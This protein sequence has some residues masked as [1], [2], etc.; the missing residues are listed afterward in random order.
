[1]RSATRVGRRDYR[2][3]GGATQSLFPCRNAGGLSGHAELG[4]TGTHFDR[5]EDHNGSEWRP[6]T[7]LPA[8]RSRNPGMSRC[9]RPAYGAA[10]PGGGISAGAARRFRHRR[11]RLRHAGCGSHRLHRGRDRGPQHLLGQPRLSDHRRWRYRLWQ[12][13]ECPPHGQG[14]RPRRRGGDPHRGP[15]VAEEM[16]PLRRQARGHPA[17]GGAA[18]D[19]RRGRGAKR[20]RQPT[21]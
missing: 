18:Q 16:R 11:H 20:D 1:M 9:Q 5:Q 12:C 17:R 7:P 4:H 3:R 10:L 14:I 6:E 8:R 13:D 2:G 15:D 21:C 19:P